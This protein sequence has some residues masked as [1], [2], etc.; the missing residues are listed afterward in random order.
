MIFEDC[1][2]EKGYYPISFSYP[3]DPYLYIK[4]KLVSDIVPGKPYSYD[5]ESL[6]LSEYQKSHY[7]ITMKK[8]GWDCMRHL[9]IMAS[10]AVPLMSDA[11]QIPKYTM[12]H[13]LKDL[14]TDIYERF[15]RTNEPP[16]KEELQLISSNFTN[17]LTC[18]SMAK[19]ILKSAGI[20]PKRVL[21]FDQ[22]LPQNEDY[23]SIM[24]LIGL[25]Q[26]FDKNCAEA[27]ITPYVY[28]TYMG[29]TKTLYGRG[30]GYSG[31]LKAN[32]ISG[33]KVP[34]DISSFDL[35]IVGSLRRNVDYITQLESS[36]VP[37]IYLYG[38]DFSPASVGEEWVMHNS[39]A[40]T[41]VREIY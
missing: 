35:I 17:N 41:F 11:R 1:Y 7:G 29:D 14:Y 31:V 2:K 10:G 32:T 40:T 27:F 37:L 16:S 12:T 26:I 25:K 9:E 6:Y 21:F 20:E 4:E 24:T 19:Y 18:K 33:I 30:F 23:L 39:R 36:N 13:H 34:Q 38:E 22:S 28:D 5:D 15:Q 3:K 8:A